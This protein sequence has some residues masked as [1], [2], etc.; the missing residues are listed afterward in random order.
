MKKP[1]QPFIAT[2]LTLALTATAQA[3]SYPLINFQVDTSIPV[4]NSLTSNLS[5]SRGN[6][7][8]D[9]QF[10]YNL[11]NGKFSCTTGSTVNGQP[12]SCNGTQKDNNFTLAISSTLSHE[13][14]TLKGATN[15]ATVKASY[16]GPLG[17][18]TNTIVAA[19]IQATP[20]PVS[21]AVTLM[22]TIDNKG[23]LTG[24]GVITSGY[25]VSHSSVALNGR[26]ALK[27]KTLTW[28]IKYPS[29]KLNFSGKE[30]L[31][32]WT[33]KLTGKIGPANISQTL[34]IPIIASTSRFHGTVTGAENIGNSP[35]EN[36]A[37]VIRSDLNNDG[38]IGD[39]ESK[40]VTTN[41]EGKFDT[42]FVTAADRRVTV[43]FNLAGYSQTPKM[44]AGVNLG[45]D[46]PI[47]TTLRKLDDLTLTGVNA[48]SDDNKLKLD[49]LPATITGLTGKVFNPVTE[50]SQFPGEFADNGGN[51]LI[52]SVFTNIQAQDNQGNKVSELANDTELRIQVPSETWN[53]M[54]DLTPANGQI[55]VPMYYYDEATGQW[56]R[57]TSD[58]WLENDARV[59]LAE[60]DLASVKD[61]SFTGPLFAV[62]NITHLSYWNI[63]W[64]IDTHQCVC[65]TIVDADGNPLAGA[66]VTA[67]GITYSGSSAPVTTGVDGKF[68]IDVMRSEGPTDD[69]NDNGIKGELQKIALTVAYNDKYYQQAETTLPDTPA[70]CPDAG[71]K[72]LGNI[73]LNSLQQLTVKLCEI[74][75]QAVYSGSWDGIDPGIAADTPL[76]NVMMF[77]MDTTMENWWTACTTNTSCIYFTNTDNL[78]KF[79]LKIPMLQGAELFG[80]KFT[81]DPSSS[82]GFQGQLDV[83]NCPTQPLTLKLDAWGYSTSGP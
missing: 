15:T 7:S 26:M 65:G 72:Q 33:G 31:D 66:I 5:L 83:S 57:S 74:T 60:T 47:S 55:D 67:R 2:A 21:S 8:I 20:A 18:L 32:A 3:T 39:G 68:C 30:V 73:A 44:Y 52:S 38:S 36:V 35:L 43:D 64:P 9:L 12:A 40:T 69:L 54:K 50:P 79:T 11:K 14:I 27:K 81:Q 48:A 1:Y 45:T 62:G 16:R 59:K 76:A 22:P 51:M 19:D 10:A 13:K 82:Q 46:V 77:G 71:C 24:S 58:G 23:K 70:S 80:W 75:G 17:K 6:A 4:M 78:G 61:R 42:Q 28:S 41:A 29:D 56:K 49:N 25:G 63:D 34:S 53:T 37:V